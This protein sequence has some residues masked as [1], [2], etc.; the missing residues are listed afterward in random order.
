MPKSHQGVPSPLLSSVS[1]LGQQGYRRSQRRKPEVQ[2]LGGISLLGYA[3][4]P[5]LVKNHHQLVARHLLPPLINKIQHCLLQLMIRHYFIPEMGKAKHISP[6][7]CREQAMRLLRAS[8][9]TDRAKTS[10]MGWTGSRFTSMLSLALLQ[11]LPAWGVDLSQ[12]PCLGGVQHCQ[13]R[14]LLFKFQLVSPQHVGPERVQGL[15]NRVDLLKNKIFLALTGLPNVLLQSFSAT[16]LETL[17][18]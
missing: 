3:N 15:Q 4:L 11:L 18:Y 17:Q 8:P 13:S 1:S 9:A 12:P 7:P 10:P 5:V 14:E 2:V 16:E 6:H